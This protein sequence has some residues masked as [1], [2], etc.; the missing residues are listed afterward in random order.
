[1]DISII[2]SFITS[3]LTEGIVIIAI[4]YAI[5]EFIKRSNISWVKKI[6]KDYIPLI[7]AGLGILLSFIPEIFPEDGIRMSM[8]KGFICGISSTGIFESYKNVKNILKTK[9][10]EKEKEK[11]EEAA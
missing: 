4:C 7:V 5:G 3:I 10:E 9:K 2:T 6:N 11:S 1:M 8:I